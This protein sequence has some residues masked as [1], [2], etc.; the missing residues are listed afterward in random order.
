MAEFLRPDSNVTQTSYTGGF[1]DIDEV[2]ASDTD[3]AFGAI[4]SSTPLLE[5]GTS[6]PASSVPA[7]TVTIRWRSA[8]RNGSG[9]IGT[10][11]NFTGT[12]ALFEGATSRASDAYTPGAFA[13][14]SFTVASSSIT[15]FNDLRLRFTQTASG[16]NNNTTRCGL[17]VSWAEIQLPEA[18][19]YI[20]IT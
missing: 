11:N 9:T 6:N 20:L 12:C 18:T 2:T 4:N 1:A 5:V 17:A 16:G 10:G 8:K 15:N 19:R 7:G 14:R 3:F 13:T